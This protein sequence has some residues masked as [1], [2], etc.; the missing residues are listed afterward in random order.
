M[1]RNSKRQYDENHQT[2][3]WPEDL[4]NEWHV[5]AALGFSQPE[6]DTWMQRDL[7][8]AQDGNDA[9][10]APWYAADRPRWFSWELE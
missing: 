7:V 3:F 5:Y 4:S 6:M 8:S 1:K 10:V 9:T 2:A